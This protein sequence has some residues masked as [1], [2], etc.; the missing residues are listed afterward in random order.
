MSDSVS[1][2][3][4][5]L[6]AWIGQWRSAVVSYSGGVDSAVVLAVA[7]RVLGK[8]AIG[9]L[10]ASPSLPERERQ[11]AVELAAAIGADFRVIEAFEHTDP[12]YAANPSNRC[13]FCKRHWYTGI[14]AIADREGWQVVLDGTNADDLGDDRPGRHAGQE[15]GVRSPLAELGI[16]KEQV[17]RLARELGLPVWDKPSAAC[18]ASRVPTGTPITP[19]LLAQ[20][21]RAEDVLASLGFRQFRVR[22]HG[23]IARIEL[24][25]EEFDGVVAFPDRIV[26]GVRA[27]GYR[28]VCLDLAGFR[29]TPSQPTAT[30]TLAPPDKLVP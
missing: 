8:A 13:Y 26:Q 29:G 28:Y 24:P 6:G 27:A 20:I 17:R 14:R 11:A 23:D 22:H 7:H 1:L 10:A 21:E 5:R 15:L 30:P 25:P 4:E 2:L 9:C 3:L 19:A 18:L 16:R 12:Q